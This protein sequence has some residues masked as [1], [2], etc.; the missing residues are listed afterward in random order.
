MQD[1]SVL[2][3]PMEQTLKNQIAALAEAYRQHKGLSLSRVSFLVRGDGQFLGKLKLAER[4][5]TIRT[6]DHC[7]AW[8]S[9]NWP[10][11]LEWPSDIP[12]PEVNIELRSAS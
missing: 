12:R 3:A 8:F 9:A 2:Y 5:F 6:F 7:L 4:T 10:E 1:L 11:D